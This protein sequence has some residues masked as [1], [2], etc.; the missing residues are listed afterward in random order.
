MIPLIRS[1]YP[2]IFLFFCFT[3]PLDKYATA[4]P[5]IVLITLLA[6]F[7]FAVK[8]E[9]FQK[10]LRREVL[11]FF[12]L[13]A[14]VA[15]GALFFQDMERDMVVIKKIAAAGL[16]LLLYI[17]LEKTENLLKTLIIATLVCIGICLY[18]M[19]WL[20]LSEGSFDFSAG[21]HVNDVLIIDRLYLGFLSILSIV[22]SVGL[23]GNKYSD[24]NKWYF[25]NIVLNVLFILLISSRIGVL[26]LLGIFLLR[27][28]Y[29][30][31]R[32]PYLLFFAGI[33][34]ITIVSFSLNKNLQE[35]FFYTSTINKDR[36]YIELV[37]HWEPRVIIWDCATDILEED[38]NTALIGNGF[39][40]TKDLLVDC[41]AGSIEE[42]EKRNYFIGE[43]FNTHN[44][45]LDFLLSYGLVPMLLFLWLFVT[46]IA[47]NRKSYVKMA[48][49]LSLLAFS[50][51]ESY[52]HR[53]IGA[54]FFSV[55]L[56]IILFPVMA[57]E[58]SATQIESTNEED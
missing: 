32:L 7:P 4:V 55:S 27:I 2:Y 12:G 53:Q 20:Y 43:R 22:A 6:L 8:K 51:I 42:E 19:Y 9:H 54:Y 52:F 15:V 21:P 57:S 13:I 49:V 3:I 23:I 26:L 39:Y 36:S 25:G 33:A 56:I 41:Y 17:P 28:L 48:M 44:Q 30:K 46:M 1:V 58:H 18:N 35:R 24:Y 47:R 45:F 10:I 11:L 38:P 29:S 34:L 14:F 5:N 40:K 37:K 50:L 31:K 16:L